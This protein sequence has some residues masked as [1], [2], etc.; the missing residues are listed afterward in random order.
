MPV[1]A[2]RFV[3][4]IETYCQ[5]C[6]HRFE[7]DAEEKSIWCPHCQRETR[8][9]GGKA[10]EVIYTQLK[11]DGVGL[12]VG[13]QFIAVLMLFIVPVLFPIWVGL[14]IFGGIL[15]R[16]VSCLRCGARLKSDDANCH[17]CGAI[18]R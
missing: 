14:I 4:I 18:I 12:G 8:L 3:V 9:A 16:R 10:K 5:H 2:T 13:L 1:P 11:R 15:A 17:I 6:H 7:A